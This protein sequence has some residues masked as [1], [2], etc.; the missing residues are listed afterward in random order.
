M[1][2]SSFYVFD[3]QRLLLTEDGAI[4]G[5][6]PPLEVT[7]TSELGVLGGR[8][9]HVARSVASRPEPPSGYAWAPVRALFLKLE[10][11]E[12]AIAGR[13]AQV[14]HFEVT[15][16][17]CGAC[18][19]PTEAVVEERL[20]RGCPACGHRAYPRI[21]P[22]VIVRIERDDTIL[23]ARHVGGPPFW[24]I[25]AGFAEVGETLEQTVAREVFEESG[26]EVTNVRYAGSQPWPFPHSLMI[27]FTAD[28]AA[29]EVRPDTTEIAE[30]RFFRADELPPV[31][32]IQSIAGQL[33]REFVDRR[34]LR[35]ANR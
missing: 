31:P 23:L 3:E 1:S 26:I 5:V 27:G 28:W 2:D 8:P 22:V 29:G 10:E 34:R 7:E 20:A 35:G 6:M 13:A 18:G 16:R 4:P 12:F 33:I 19:G 14:A 32:P 9:R 24:T 30:A 21:S 25:L 17:F 15:H 11:A